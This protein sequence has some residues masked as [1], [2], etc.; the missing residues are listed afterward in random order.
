MRS[1][2]ADT[3][4]APLAAW[5]FTSVG[6]MVS[7]RAA[8]SRRRLR[9]RAGSSPPSR[10]QDAA[11]SYAPTTTS[12]DVGAAAVSRGSTA[13]SRRTIS[14]RFSRSSGGGVRCSTE[15][16]S[17]STAGCSQRNRA[18]QV[19]H[20]RRGA[21]ARDLV[22][23]KGAE[24]VGSESSSSRSGSLCGSRFTATPPRFLNTH[25]LGQH[26]SSSSPTQAACGP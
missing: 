17:T 23:A 21:P 13:A 12:S 26:E 9:R 2:V 16:G 5:A 19:S 22:L 4:T 7:C 25:P 10:S 6:S 14:I 20:R 11:R 3:G 24:R 1:R 18:E 8:R 15:A